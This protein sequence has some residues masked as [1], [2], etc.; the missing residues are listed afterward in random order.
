MYS[1]GDKMIEKV[2]SVEFNT[3]T[4]WTRDTVNKGGLSGEYLHIPL[5]GLL[6]RESELHDYAQYGDGYKSI[7]LVGSMLFDIERHPGVL[8]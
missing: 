6:V 2:Y 1:D 3:Y 5:G 4:S 7:T 8:M